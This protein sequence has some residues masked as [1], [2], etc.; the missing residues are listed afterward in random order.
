MDQETLSRSTM[1]ENIPQPQ[2]TYL[3]E[4][5]A[6]NR[7]VIGDEMN[8]VEMNTVEMNTVRMNTVRMNRQCWWSQRSQRFDHH[9]KETNMDQEQSHKQSEFL[10]QSDVREKQLKDLEERREKQLKDLE[11]RLEKQLKDIEE[12]LEKQLKDLE[13][14]REKQLKDLEER[15]EK[16]LKDLEE[17]HCQLYAEF[18]ESRVCQKRE[19]NVTLKRQLKC[20]QEEHEVIRKSVK[21]PIEQEAENTAQNTSVIGD[22]M[23]TV[24]TNRQCWWSGWSRW[25]RWSWWSRWLRW[26]DHQNKETNM[27]QE[28]IHKQR[29]DI[30]ELRQKPE[31]LK[32]SDV[33]EKQLKDLE[34]HREKLQKE[35]KGVKS[36]IAYE[37]WRPHQEMD[38]LRNEIET[39]R[40]QL[41]QGE[42]YEMDSDEMNQE[43]S[44]FENYEVADKL[45]LE[46][47]SSATDD[48]IIIS[49]DS[50]K[51]L[52][53]KVN[54]TDLS[55]DTA[56]NRTVI[57]DEMNTVEMNT[58]EMNTVEMNTVEMNI[59]E[60]NTVE[61][62]TVRMNTV[63]M[64]TV[65]MNT[66]RMNT[67]RMNRQC[68]WS[69]R[70][71]WFDHHN[72]ETNMD[73][74]Q[75]HK[76]LEK[77]LKDLEEQWEKQLKDLEERREKQLKDLEERQEKQL[78]D[79]EEYH[80][81][82][83]AEFI[84]SRVCQ[85][86]EENVTLK[87]Q[88]KCQ[89]EE[90]EVICKSVKIPIEQEAENT[91][92]N[93]SVIGDEM[94]TVET[95]RQCW[96][97]GWSR[98]LR[99]SW[100]SRWLRWSWW[101]QWFDYQNKESNMDQETLSRST[102]DEN[103]PQ[104][105]CTYLSED[106]AQNRS[107]IG[108]EM[109]TVEMNTVEMNTVRMNTV[110][111]N[112]QCWWS[113]R[114]QRF[115]HHNKE[116]NMDQEQSHKQSEFLKQSD[117]REK[118]LKDLEERRE[119]QL[120][121]LEE[122]LEKQLK[123]IEERLE[124]QLK[125]L[126]ERRE[127]QLKDLEERREK[128]LKDLEEYHCQ[129]Y[130]EFIESRVCQ[131]REEN[132]TLKR[133]L[134][135]QQE[136]HE[137]IRKSVKIPIEQEAENTAQNTSVI[138]DEM[139][140]VETN[141]QCWWSG[142]SR[143][144][145]WSWWSRWLRWFDHQNKET[146]MD[147]EQIH[148]QRQDIQELR[149]KPEFLKQSDVMEKQLK[150]LE[151]HREKL[152]KEIK[153]V[154]SL[155]AYERWRPHQEMDT[156]RN[157][158]ETI[159]RQLN[160]GEEYEMDSDEMNQEPS[161]FENY[162]V[163]DK[164][165]LESTSSATDDG[166]IISEDSVKRLLEK[167][168]CTDLS[169]DTAQ[170]RTVIGDEMNTVEMNTVEMNTVEMNTVEMNIVEMNTVEM[171]TVRMNTVEMS[172]V[173]MNTVRM[174]TVR[175]N[176]Q[177]W[178]SQRS[179]WFDH[180]NKETNM[181]QEQSHKQLEKQLKDLEE[182]WEKQ[183]KDLEERREKQL[184]DLEERQ[185]K[186]L[187]DLEEYHCQL[188]AE[189]IESRVCQKREE[190][191][192]LKRQ[193]KCQQEEHEVI[194]K[195]VK[196]PIEQEAENTAQNTSVI[197]DEMNTVET[198]RQCW[199]SGWSRWLRWSWWS[200]WLR[201]SWWL[202]WFDYQNKESNMDQETLSRSTMDENIPQPQCTYLSEDTAQNRSVIGDE[203][204][205]VEMNTV[206]MNTVRM[207]T[208]RM[209]RQCWWSQR[210]QRFDHHNKETN[211][212][213]EQSHKQ[214][215]FL[216]QSDVR[217]KQL[218]DLEERR[219][220]QLK[221]L[222]ERLEKQLKDIEERLEKQLKDLEERREKQLKD[223]EERREKQLKDLEEYHCQL[224]A[225]F[226][227]SRVCQKREENVTLKRQLKCQQEEHEV[228]RKSVK[229]P[230]EQEAENTAQNTSVIGD[231]MNTVETNRQCWWSGWSRWLRWSWWSRWLRWFDH[232]N[233][234]TNMD[235]EQIHKQRQDIQELRQ[236]PEFLK[237]SDVMEK[238]LKDLEEHREKL[239]KE[240]KG[241]KSLI[242][243]ERW[244]PHQEM[245]TLRNEIETIRRQLN[246]GEE[247]EMDSDEMNQEP[248]WH[249]PS[250][251]WMSRTAPWCI[252]FGVLR[253]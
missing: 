21:I 146:N 115:D 1:D 50:V 39:I 242:A 226:I 116:T 131:K 68:W 47:T 135:C 20:Q 175:M 42:E 186:Q 108:D 3:S 120:K 232:Q 199:W 169:E 201:W 210:S 82:L 241:V 16:Q 192:T 38:T 142:W 172:T 141:R 220:K 167:V 235:Q 27:D 144:L 185:E 6:Q 184:K 23:N 78:K 88:L 91:A 41:N 152:Q 236:K 86:R 4:D 222:E 65:E 243:Y 84:E 96:W 240:I 183:L 196:I 58:V 249:V 179:Q 245:D 11:E 205:T 223:L 143:W 153:G 99:W 224:Y 202:Q 229:I 246:Q 168:N 170:N 138:G 51:R 69:Q 102:M 15:R 30:Q 177:C 218:K 31:F 32:Q 59:V 61:M 178:W 53:E 89:Q 122:R 97:S 244:R 70:S 127:K 106:T 90:H 252:T 79:L 48:G 112:R 233:K 126:E 19:E 71:Q 109:N 212:D 117:V 49:E 2:C 36:L 130:A 200:R 219:E 94:N 187:K 182:Q 147:Q 165:P 119:K 40:R 238:Q 87:R 118:Q 52:L 194:C 44:W 114:S 37:R 156:L 74:E 157:E 73:Q 55:E 64:S 25:L 128:Q 215:E 125:D 251:H 18:I 176:R 17:Y 132:V 228:I 8:T 92:Q 123:D 43:P 225:E 231:E 239:Q 34:E 81:Q 206:E 26:F 66:V 63:E 150:D 140:T 129:L 161:W 77:Q 190:N 80:C 211:M 93:T 75:S 195:S 7:S 137:V 248:S 189:F 204:N 85:K 213:Q 159:R 166:I 5:T 62:N 207:N 171:N 111:M 76:Q 237:Q 164:L 191:V 180:H 149:Q 28:Q 107:V 230:I 46:S 83:Y 29:Q 22:E 151:E 113:Q 214:S 133:Q 56:Q 139:N 173:E 148:K 198:N 13:E 100:W 209:N 162:E 197:G 203:M 253:T 12:R 188:Y 163:A 227:E 14:R 174:N 124:K 136:E 33:M 10:K 216:K 221:D 35:I 45:P 104:P 98:W 95:N 217:E 60:M 72:K 24:E 105:Q 57:G 193:L 67:V 154:K 181:D 247:Y 103:I 155:I 234:E 158:I 54:C 101:L 9:N 145:R 121:D 208:V 110:R 250:V 134:K 160:Q